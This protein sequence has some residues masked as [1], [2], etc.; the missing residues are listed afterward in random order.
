MNNTSNLLT[1]F[2]FLML[3]LAVGYLGVDTSHLSCQTLLTLLLGFLL[4]GCNYWLW[5]CPMNRV[6]DVSSPDQSRT[7]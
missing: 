6:R 3:H 2:S 7:Y 1:K 5:L 4:T